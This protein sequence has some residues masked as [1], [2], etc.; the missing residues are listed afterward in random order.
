[1]SLPKKYTAKLNRKDE[2]K[3]E[4]ALNRSRKAYRT[5]RGKQRVAAQRAGKCSANLHCMAGTMP[6]QP[7]QG[8]AVKTK[9]TVSLH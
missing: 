3:Q 6:P 7:D 4:R 2:I 1:M 8:R 5:K 9:I